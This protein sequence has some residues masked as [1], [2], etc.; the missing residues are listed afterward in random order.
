MSIRVGAIPT[1]LP[2]FLA[3][4]LGQ[5]R[6]LHPEIEIVLTEDMTRGLVER[7]TVP[8]YLQH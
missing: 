7:T 8:L 6:D 1:I 2:F 3:P 5:F 4:R